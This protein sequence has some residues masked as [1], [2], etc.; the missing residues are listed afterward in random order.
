[1]ISV[2]HLDEPLSR[3][4]LIP[5]TELLRASSPVK[6][7]K[8]I[9]VQI[10]KADKEEEEEAESKLIIFFGIHLSLVCRAF[11]RSSPYK[12]GIV[13]MVDD[14]IIPLLCSKRYTLYARSTVLRCPIRVARHFFLESYI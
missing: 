2:V 1:M 7:E 12:L 3:A 13:Y 14:R 8:C 5:M 11:D 9:H 6:Q 10:V 4:A